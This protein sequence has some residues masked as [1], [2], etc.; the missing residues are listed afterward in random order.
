LAWP[1]DDDAQ[2]AKVMVSEKARQVNADFQHLFSRLPEGNVFGVKKYL[3]YLAQPR[4]EVETGQVGTSD[5]VA[6]F[7][8]G[9][10]NDFPAAEDDNNWRNEP[11]HEAPDLLKERLHRTPPRGGRDAYFS[12]QKGSPLTSAG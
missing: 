2:I 10:G 1:E 12:G 8:F 4:Q 7:I 3:L 9:Q 6:V 5:V 11:E